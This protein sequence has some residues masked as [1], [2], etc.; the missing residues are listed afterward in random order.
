[1]KMSKLASNF[2][3]FG[4]AQTW[5]LDPNNRL[6][7][8]FIVVQN[9]LLWDSIN[10]YNKY[11]RETLTLNLLA[12]EVAME[13]ESKNNNKKTIKRKNEIMNHLLYDVVFESW[14]NFISSNW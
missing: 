9:K 3:H 7:T 8:L 5:D 13:K 10:V 12:K 11:L 14:V 4:L 6:S 2:R 1:M